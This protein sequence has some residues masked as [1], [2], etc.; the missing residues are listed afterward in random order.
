MQIKSLKLNFE[1]AMILLRAVNIM[2]DESLKEN[3]TI[4]YS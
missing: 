4:I 1:V 2:L 3:K